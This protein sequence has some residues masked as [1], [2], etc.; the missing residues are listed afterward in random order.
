MEVNS[1]MPDSFPKG[2]VLAK[3]KTKVVYAVE[4]EPGKV[5]LQSMDDITVFDDPD[6][7][8]RF[9][10]KAVCATTT[11]SQ[12]FELLENAGL[13][14]A[15]IEQV[16]KTEFLARKCEMILL[17]AV[18]R[19]IAKGS[20]PKR[21]PEVKDGTRFSDPIC[22][23]FLKTTGGK[24]VLP[25][26][27]V[28][29]EGLD[30][31]KGEED[32]FIINPDDEVWDLFHPKK[33]PSEKGA[34]LFRS[35][36]AALVVPHQH[37]MKDMEKVAKGTFS[38]LEEAWG[39]LNCQL[40]DMKIEFGIDPEGNLVIADVVDNDNWRLG[41]PDGKEISKEFFRQGGE[42]GEVEEKYQLVAKLVQRP[43][44]SN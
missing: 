14:V 8:R 2:K 21:N 38:V 23:F 7:T 44:F 39:N 32:P 36:G 37:S 19:R 43:E 6:L 28:V 42:L 5:V 12:V 20:Y 33:P 3:G 15:Y 34:N 27:R 40:V 4:G 25:D 16:S 31:K 17:E 24:L 41:D 22:E 9:G 11:T 26:G 18:I 29:V 1:T 10:S 13:P 30:P 35:L